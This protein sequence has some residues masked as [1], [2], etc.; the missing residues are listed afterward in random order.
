[1]P[2]GGRAGRFPGLGWRRRSLRLR[3]TVVA[4]AAIAAGSVAAVLLLVLS[5]RS[6]LVT[7]LDDEAHARAAEAV[8]ALQRGDLAGAVSTAGGDSQVQVLGPDGRVVAA[9][10]GLQGRP[11]LVARGAQAGRHQQPDGH[12]GERDVRVLSVTTDGGRVVVV[13]S[14]LEEVEQSLAQLA[15]RVLVGGPVLLALI[16]AAVWLLVGYTLGTVERLR[17]QVA[18]L[19]VTGLEGRVE[20]PEARDEVRQLAVTM[21]DLLARM[22]RASL[23][24]RR[25]VADAAHELRSPLA[26]LRARVEVSERSADLERWQRAA[27]VLVSDAQRLA[28]LVDGLLALARLDESPQLLQCVPVD[29]DEVV[30]AEVARLRPTT[31]AV[32]DTR[33]VGAALVHGDPDLLHRIVGNLLSNAVRHAAH[34]VDVA[35]HTEGAQVEL[36]VADDG[37]GIPADERERVFERFQRLDGARD[38]DAGGS[39]LGLAIVRDAVRAHRGAVTLEDARPG[40]R[41]TV[42]LPAVPAELPAVAG[43]RPSG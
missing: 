16:G 23:A 18:Q 26:A 6:G 7:G 40:V 11:P 19:S 14:S 39:G 10:P 33:R 22:H 27:P 37:P 28:D 38:R 3:V 25:F 43:A 15:R 13:A 21:N 34:R 30:F 36:T 31:V 20:L 35:V 24:Q 4:T 12:V 2:D 32:L 9:S 17:E 41:A 8:V 5:L 42:R 1:M 29:L